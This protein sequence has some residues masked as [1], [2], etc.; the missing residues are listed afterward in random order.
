[1]SDSDIGPDKNFLGSVE[2][3]K[4][5]RCVRGCAT[6]DQYVE[7]L[8]RID[9]ERERLRAGRAAVCPWCK[10]KGY[11]SGDPE[12]A[13]IEDCQKCRGTGEVANPMRAAVWAECR[14]TCAKVAEQFPWSG[15]ETARAIR[16][17]EVPNE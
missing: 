15:Y 7:L 3:H 16:A 8:W 5:A 14:E 11:V 13:P 9:K 2:A 10:G 17:L 6:D 1:M 12:G 4:I